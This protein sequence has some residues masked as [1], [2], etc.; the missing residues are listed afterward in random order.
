MSLTPSSGSE[1]GSG[2]D[3]GGKDDSE[4]RLVR[5]GGEE[6]GSG[7]LERLRL[8]RAADWKG[9]REVQNHGR[10]KY[11][12]LLWMDVIKWGGGRARFAPGR[13]SL[14]RDSFRST[15]LRGARR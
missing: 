8:P 4:S 5:G 9:V 7:E 3:D 2:G 11:H 1:K 14:A 6:P 12:I 10:D 13:V 15:R